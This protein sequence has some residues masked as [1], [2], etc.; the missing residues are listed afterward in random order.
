V[1]VT[2]GTN[3]ISAEVIV[4]G[5]VVGR[6]LLV[7]TTDLV[8]TKVKVLE[9]N[10]VLTWPGRTLGAFF[11]L[12]AVKQMH[13]AYLLQMTCAPREIRHDFTSDFGSLEG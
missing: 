4:K 6:P 2:T 7:S 3:E 10:K 13:G 12:C 8:V 1:V 11:S 5:N 9:V